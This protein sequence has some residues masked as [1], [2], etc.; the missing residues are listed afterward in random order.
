MTAASL[1]KM[2]RCDPTIL[3][4]VRKTA[5]RKHEVF[6]LGS[7][8]YVAKRVDAGVEILPSRFKVV[9]YKVSGDDGSD[10]VAEFVHV[11]DE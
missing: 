9:I 2:P 8:T 3:A 5:P 1:L 7:V 6:K 11:D 10:C 4:R